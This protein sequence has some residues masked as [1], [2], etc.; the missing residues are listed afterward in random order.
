MKTIQINID[1]ELLERLDRR[2]CGKAKARSA[3]V[4]AAIERELRR[5]EVAELEKQWRDGYLRMP[6]KPGEFDYT[7][8]DSFWE[9]L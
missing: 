4:R 3:F 6:A 2:L 1:E 5:A 8:D 7:P 9:E